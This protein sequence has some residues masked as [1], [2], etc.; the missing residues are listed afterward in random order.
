VPI[1]QA[2]ATLESSNLDRFRWN[3]LFKR[4]RPTF[5]GYRFRVCDRP[6]ITTNGAVPGFSRI[7]VEGPAIG[8]T[9]PTSQKYCD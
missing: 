3:R 4:N 2:R 7:A 6:G 1:C 9:S 5:S 8:S